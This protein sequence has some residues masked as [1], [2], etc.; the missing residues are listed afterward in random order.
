MS[1]TVPSEQRMA[2]QIA[3]NFR[4][5]PDDR[6]AEA[7]AAHIGRFWD[8]RMRAK[9][10]GLVNAGAEGLDPVVVA[11]ARLLP[12]PQEASAR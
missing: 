2:N 7:I 1:G 11:A 4:H 12:Q 8:P 10:L 5:V 3:L 9:L 6:A